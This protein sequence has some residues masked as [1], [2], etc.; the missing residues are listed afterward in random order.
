MEIKKKTILPILILVFVG[1]SPIIFLSR[2]AEEEQNTN[3]SSQATQEDIT[4]PDSKKENDAQ[5]GM[6]LNVP[7]T[8][9][10]PLGNWSDPRQQNGCEEAAAL[11]AMAWVKGKN[12]T[13]EEAEKE[14]IAIAD[15]ELKNY[16]HFHDSSAQDLV[17]RVFKGYFGYTKIEVRY[18]INIED[19]KKE[20]ASGNLILVPANGKILD[21]PFYT[22]PPMEHMV[23]VR[24]YDS[25][26]KEFIVNDSGTSRGELFQYA[27]DTLI[28][29]IYDYPTGYH[30]PVSE[31][32]KVM[33]IVKK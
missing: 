24:G 27:E 14:I 33:I 5:E 23:V 12:L 28:D 1:I 16:G 29:A 11:M 2:E 3:P 4:P 7:F 26:T 30:E 15:Y 6:V 19:I 9:Q 31:L 13:P 22:E 17:E 8:A 10:A 18:D 21:N 32:K 20:L 25:H